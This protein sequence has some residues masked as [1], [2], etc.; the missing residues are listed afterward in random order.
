MAAATAPVASQRPV[1]ISNNIVMPIA[2]DTT[3]IRAMVVYVVQV[4]VRIY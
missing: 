4:D 2:C 1:A 3:R